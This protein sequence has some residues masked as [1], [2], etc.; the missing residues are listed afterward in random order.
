M[1]TTNQKML[2]AQ[3]KP[4]PFCGEHVVFKRDAGNEVWPQSFNIG[5]KK[6][7]FSFGE[8]GSSSWASNKKED[9]AATDKVIA[10]WNS[11]A[12]VKAN[13]NIGADESLRAQVAQ[14]AEQL[15][16]MRESMVESIDLI[17]HFEI[18]DDFSSLYQLKKDI[19]IDAVEVK[20]GK[21]LAILDSLEVE[22]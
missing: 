22:G 2:E 15:K 18:Y 7:S 17:K 14:Q 16:V 4:C 10:R 19:D 5:C 3:L 20:C 12:E 9:K 11:R 13:Q 21:A 8:Y 1:S 6:C